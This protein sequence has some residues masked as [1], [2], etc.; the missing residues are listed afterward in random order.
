MQTLFQDFRY[1]L[2]MLAKTPGFTAV[3][4]L[5]LALGIG[6]NTAIF[7]AVNGILLKPLPYADA[8]RLVGITSLKVAGNAGL[9]TG[10]ATA[11]ARDI[12]RQCPAIEQL[13][14]SDN[15]TYTFTGQMAPEILVGAKVPGNFFTL[16]GVRPMLGRPILSS[17]TVAGNSDVVVL[18]YA[19]WKELLGGDR[20][21]IG[22]KITLNGKQYI[23]IGVMP[24]QFDLGIRGRG[25]WMPRVPTPDDATDR[26]SRM[27]DVVARL[28]PGTTVAAVQAQLN[29]LSARLTAA[30]PKTDAG[31]KLNA[32]GVKESEV[33]SVTEELLLLLGAVGFVLLIA[34]VNVSGL[35]LARGWARQKEVAIRE[36]LGAS[37]LRII[38]QFL[39]ESVLL[40]LAGGALGLLFSVWGIHLLRATA[41][42]DTPRVNEVSLNAMVLWFTLGVSLVAGILF[43]LAPAMQ[44][45]APRFGTALKENS[46]GSPGGFS[47]RR[48]RK[49]RSVLVVVEVALAVILVVGATLVARSFEKLS[50]LDLGF[51]TDHLL[52]MTVNFSKA[53]CDK[54]SKNSATQCRLADNNVLARVKELPGVE[55][56]AEASSVP[57][58][59]VSPA[60]DLRVVG[61]SQKL[62]F[63]NGAPVLYRLVTSEFFSAM[64]MRLLTGRAFSGTYTVGSDREAIVNETFAKQYLSNEPLG[65]RISL[66]KDTRGQPEWMDVVG[67]V[68]DTQDFSL[69]GYTFPEFYAPRSQSSTPSQL[70]LIA[71]TAGSPMAMVAAVRSQVWR[72]D[73]DAPITQ[74]K[75][76]GQILSNRAAEPRFQTLLLGSFGV[77]GLVLAMVGIYGVIS[78]GVT[79]RT[80]EIGV[81][82]T[83]GAQPASI[84]RMTI[85]EGMLLASAGVAIG[86][87]GALAL[88]R[89]LQSLLF[90]IKPTDPATFVGVATALLIVALAACWIP[91]QRAMK[92][93]PMEALR[94]E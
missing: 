57:L 16:L 47:G 62:G 86:I 15:T 33:G 75:T 50:N 48:S 69:G 70:S 24:P 77:L 46:G 87:C 34:C 27:E 13:A 74:L 40:A 76:M 84:L 42:P 83:L 53:V 72:V 91:A 66:N 22:R 17:D 49:L 38:R 51:R 59:G 3:A 67:E 9:S 35:L 41:P 64:G 88:G 60:M 39:A 37:R 45:S 26:E 20:G 36:A 94:Y 32:A 2:R 25:V 54:E 58:E 85:R 11:A 43:G 79:L 65:K 21:W 90:E 92:I 30:Y 5:T 4:V 73:K 31:W 10:V 56:V 8:A 18:S 19:V 93:E 82:M 23:V 52:T 6:A 71:R 78:Y 7:S 63:S 29:T 68:S 44:A 28:K 1:G 89:V 12:E 61:Q 55:N 81:R 14:A 80:H